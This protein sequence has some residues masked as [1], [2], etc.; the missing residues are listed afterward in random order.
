MRVKVFSLVLC[1][2]VLMFVCDVSNG[3]DGNDNW[4]CIA[5]FTEKQLH[6]SRVLL[7]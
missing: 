6:R 3:E 7:R 1:V 2:C 4:L 5:T